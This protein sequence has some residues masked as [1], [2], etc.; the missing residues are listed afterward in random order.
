[1]KDIRT[2]LSNPLVVNDSQ[3]HL[4]PSSSA[5]RRKSL[6]RSLRSMS[7]E[8]ISLQE[9]T[10]VEPKSKII[11]FRA[12]MKALNINL[13]ME[14]KDN[15][16]VRTE[17]IAINFE[18]ICTV[19]DQRRKRLHLDFFNIQVDNQLYEAG[20]FDF[21][22]IVCGQDIGQGSTVLPIFF[23]FDDY[24]EKCLK[25]ALCSID[26]KLFD[27][28][29][30]MESINLKLNPIRAYIEDKY[31]NLVM[32]FLMECLPNNLLY[33]PEETIERIRCPPGTVLLPK[34]IVHQ[35]IDCSEPFQLRSFTI[36]P[37]KM[38]LSV[39]TCMR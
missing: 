31:L 6:E 10:T 15:H 28:A 36:E 11:I 19:L 5:R 33:E 9:E 7:P 14:N 26:I 39:H 34:I 32:D 30:E 3:P 18:D 22:V 29:I 20:D 27:R 12:F 25:K 17:I 16:N 4:N 38:L 35:S 37:F 13:Y 2:R 8:G 23:E 21:N 1:M 24:F